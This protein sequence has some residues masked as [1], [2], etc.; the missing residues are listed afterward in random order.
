MT[1]PNIPLL[2]LPTHNVQITWIRHA[3][4]LIQLGERYQ[5]L[6]D[7]VLAPI[8]GAAGFFMQFYDTFELQAEPPIKL[9]DLHSI[10]KSNHSTE[11]KKKNIVVI[12][13]DHHDHLNWNTVNKLPANTHFY[14]PLRLEKAFPPRFS[15]VIGMDWYTK[16]T[17]GELNIHFLP[18]NHRSGR[19][20]NIVNQT[21][22]GGWL[23]EWNNY[24][25]Y[26][27]GDSGYS[28]VFKDIAKRFGEIDV[29]LMPISAWFQRNWHFA[30]EDAIS[31]AQDLGCK[32]FIPWGYGTWIMSYEHILEPTR[33]LKYAW[34][35]MDTKDMDLR[36]LKM[37]ETY[38]ID[39]IS[40]K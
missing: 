34:E 33:R 3:T 38:L 11:Y 15:S 1:N 23:F 36:M 9:H 28:L 24:R 39:A 7:P 29:C 18:A 32:T 27:A 6:I 12:S 30:P 5:I 22:W 17:L 16:D 21:L 14:V 26:F 10:M 40:D 31:A 20:L 37:G 2:R 13:H 4:F 8:D 19:S 25:I 35:K